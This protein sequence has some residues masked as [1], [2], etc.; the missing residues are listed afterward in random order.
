MIAVL[1]VLDTRYGSRY[2]VVNDKGIA[3][4]HYDTYEYYL[5]TQY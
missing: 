3:F 1:F 2:V 5:P 4:K